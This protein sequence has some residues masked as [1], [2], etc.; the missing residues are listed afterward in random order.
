MGDVALNFLFSNREGSKLLHT[1][2]LSTPLAQVKIWLAS[3]WPP[4]AGVAP[5]DL[6]RI[7]LICMGTLLNA[8]DSTLADCSVR[9]LDGPTP[10]NVSVRPEGAVPSKR[11]ETQS[12]Q[13][14][15]SRRVG[16]S[17]PRP[18]APRGG[19]GCCVLS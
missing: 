14:Q 5:G 8:D 17:P 19:G 9:V 7:R 12:A 11:R 18:P 1:T 3:N 10:V 4:A 2:P 6:S 16:T 15:Q 13:G